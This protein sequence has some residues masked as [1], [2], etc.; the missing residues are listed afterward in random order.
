MLNKVLAT[1]PDNFDT[2]TDDE[3]GV[4][5]VTRVHEG[6]T[7]KGRQAHGDNIEAD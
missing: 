5:G 1:G 4:T 2:M 6:K 3:K 7:D